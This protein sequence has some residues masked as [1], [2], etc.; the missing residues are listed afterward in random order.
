MPAVAYPSFD[1]P[2]PSPSSAQ[3]ELLARLRTDD[4]SAYQSLFYQYFT[5]LCQF[6]LTYSTSTDAA[7]DIVQEVMIWVWE[8]RHS[9]RVNG[10]LSTYLYQAVRNRAL[11]AQRQEQAR[12]QWEAQSVEEDLAPLGSQPDTPL[13]VE[14]F[15]HVLA[16][17]ID[18]LPER[19]RT[20]FV[21]HR[22]HGLSQQEIA[23]VMGTTVKTVENQMGLAL[24]SLR[25]VLYPVFT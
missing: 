19:R 7:K 18:Q 1:M 15:A 20:I 23:Q 4:L 22:Q 12:R 6:A 16:K 17:A 9:L 13:R 14:Q 11:N 2:D 3:A 5:R 21:L 25:V 10:L 24:K 8:H